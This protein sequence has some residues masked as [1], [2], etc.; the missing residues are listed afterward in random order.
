MIKFFDELLDWI[1]KKKC[2]ICGRSKESLKICSECY[3]KLYFNDFRSLKI[4]EGVDIYSAGTYTNELQKMIRGL[5]YHRQKEL[6]FYLA[7][8][9]AEYWLKLNMGDAFQV[10]PV[11]L[12]KNRRR[13]RGYNHMELVADEFCKITGYKKN[14]A[15]ISRIKDTVAQYKLTYN[16]RIQNLENAFSVDKE[17]LN[18]MPILII[19]DITTTGATFESMVKELRKSGVENKIICLSISNPE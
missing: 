13:K 11:P 4:I 2:Y 10:I 14:L 9:L 3:N 7:K 19:D 17:N 15:L 16:K 6:A 12:H 5:K 1:Y 8:F 18:D